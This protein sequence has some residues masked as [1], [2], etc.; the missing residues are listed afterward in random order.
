MTT[1]TKNDAQVLIGFMGFAVSVLL[2]S[3]FVFG[4]AASTIHKI[5]IALSGF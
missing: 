2:V 4:V 5:V 1:A 3:A